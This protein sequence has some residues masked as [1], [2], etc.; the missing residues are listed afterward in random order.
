MVPSPVSSGF[1]DVHGVQRGLITV[2][3]LHRSGLDPHR[4]LLLGSRAL[5]A[6]TGDGVQAFG[7]LIADR[8]WLRTR[9]GIDLDVVWELRPVLMAIQNGLD[10]ARLWR[11]DAVI[12][13]CAGRLSGVR[14]RWRLRGVQ[15]LLRRLIEDV[16][17]STHVLLVSVG[18]AR[19]N[20]ERARHASTPTAEAGSTGHE[21][22]HR[23]PIDADQRVG[24]DA[25]A[26]ALLAP[27][28]ASDALSADRGD[29]QRV[30]MDEERGR[31]QAV[32][33]LALRGRQVQR[34]LQQVVNT[35][36]ETFESAAAEI[37]IIDHDQQWTM[38]ASGRRRGTMPRAT[39]LC[40]RTITRVNPTV[41]GDVWTEPDLVGD[42]LIAATEPIRFYAAHP[43]ES[44]DGYRIGVLCV[45]DVVPHPV[46]DFDVGALRDLAL[47]AEAEIISASD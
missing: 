15:R 29:G 46:A 8:V 38:A 26:C 23:L 24:A 42:P 34:R 33:D 39:S 31:Q 27:F 41:I 14:G 28:A 30:R 43:I 5:L 7:S 17:A 18:D 45:W 20:E 1:A 22:E 12:V 21:A 19:R 40:N 36:Q 3:R 9:R 44:I 16:A 25:I 35:A 37:T 11:Y 2:T 4:V 10:A 6:P 13:L 47:L 32:N